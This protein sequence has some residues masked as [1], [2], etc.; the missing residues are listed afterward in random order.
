MMIRKRFLAILAAPFLGALNA[1]AQTSSGRKRRDVAIE[2]PSEEGYAFLQATVGI[3]IVDRYGTV[4]AEANPD[5]DSIT[6]LYAAM[7]AEGGISYGGHYFS[8]AKFRKEVLRKLR[9]F[10][11]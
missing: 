5:R 11:F 2:I 6:D 10:L 9:D 4:L 7:F 1:R 8:D 3:R